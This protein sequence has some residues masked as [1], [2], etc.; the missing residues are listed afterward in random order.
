[1]RPL[2]DHLVTAPAEGATWQQWRIRRIGGGA[3]NVLYRATSDQTDL[4]I[5]FTIR[6]ERDRAGRE[7]AA[8]QALQQ[9][10]LNLAPQSLLL[11]RERY[12]Q[13]VIVQTWVAGSVLDAPPDS[14]EDWHKLLQHLGAIHGLTP[15]H[16]TPP[17]PTVVLTMRSAAEGR[18][19]I[20]ENVDRIPAD[21]RPA[22][23]QDLLVRLD[24]TTFPTWPA[25]QSRLCRG[26]CHCRNFLR[27]PGG[28]ASVDWEYSGWGDP[29]FEVADLLSALSFLQ[30]TPDRPEWAIKQYCARSAD[31]LVALRIQTYYRLMLIW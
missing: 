23:L 24:C 30:V 22:S 2:L 20:Q 12:P 14:D 27:R 28:W 10:G 11:D 4:A 13:P 1:L 8:L 15:E 18:A 21:Q 3:N 31:P 19:R 29:A 7:Y 25:V 5:K 17:L 9:C 6:D 16:G 26:D